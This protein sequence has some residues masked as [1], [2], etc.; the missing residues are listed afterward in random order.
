MGPKAARFCQQARFQLTGSGVTERLEGTREDLW[1][2]RNGK[3]E[4]AARSSRSERLGRA[5]VCARL[6]SFGGFVVVSSGGGWRVN[7]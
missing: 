2:F 6:A 5:H 4:F 3:V 1:T 7:P